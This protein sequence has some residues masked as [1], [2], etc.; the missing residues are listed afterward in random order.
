MAT[1]QSAPAG[2]RE[3]QPP[4]Y[5][6]RRMPQAL[7]PAMPHLIAFRR[8]RDQGG[9]WEG[10]R[11]R[12][13]PAPPP[14]PPPPPPAPTPGDEARRFY[15]SLWAEEPP[16]HAP[17]G[18]TPAPPTAERG[19]P[20]QAGGG[21]P[22][23]APHFCPTCGTHFRD[24]PARHRSSTAHLLARGG[25]AP[26]PLPPFHIPPTNYS[27]PPNRPCDPQRPP[28]PQV[29]PGPS[30]PPQGLPDPLRTPSVPPK[31]PPSSPTS[32]VPT[33]SSRSIL[34]PNMAFPAQRPPGGA[35]AGRRFRPA[36][37]VTSARA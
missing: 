13:P 33:N 30:S 26:P 34:G 35:G 4:A 15:E 24:P 28:D 32:P 2:G 11:L 16:P 21:E 23:R 18:Q 36:P 6:R 22:P 31:S 25:G 1:D 5:G 37:D 8:G 29:P 10:G 9:G 3:R 17:H 12:D 20:P 27:P 7:P 14:S 19:G